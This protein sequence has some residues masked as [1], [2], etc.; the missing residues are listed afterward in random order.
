MFDLHDELDHQMTHRRPLGG[1]LMGYAEKL[2]S[3]ALPGGVPQPAGPS[4]GARHLRLT[5]QG[6][7]RGRGQE[8]KIRSGGW[9]DPRAGRMTFSFYVEQQWLPNRVM[10]QSTRAYYRRLPIQPP[11]GVRPLELRH[12]PSLHRAALD[13]ED[14]RSGAKAST[15]A[16]KARPP[17]HA[18]GQVRR[19]GD[20]RP[21]DRD[22]P[23]AACSSQRRH[24]PRRLDLHPRRKP[25]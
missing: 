5:T 12:D 13:R 7:E 17:D 15:I 18:R 14:D 23:C 11:R 24:G 6:Q 25:A 4:S 22:N 8:T 10:E 1:A 3:G 19:L 2:P 16:A 9:F 21:A 20:P